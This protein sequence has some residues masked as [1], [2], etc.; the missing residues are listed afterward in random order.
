MS[1]MR[2]MMR[3]SQKLQR[4]HTMIPTMT[5]IPP[6]LTPPARPPRR[7]RSTAMSLLPL[8]STTEHACTRSARSLR[9]RGGVVAD[10]DAIPLDA[11]DRLPRHDVDVPNPCRRPPRLRPHA[12]G[13]EP[14]AP[15]ECEARC[16]KAR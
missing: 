1:P 9:A 6:R 14:S 4:I 12:A 5:R 7:P 10:D 15:P 13:L 2:A 8:D 16:A 11:Q 3:P